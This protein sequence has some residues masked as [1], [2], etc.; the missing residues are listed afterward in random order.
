MKLGRG[1]QPS[2]L[3]PQKPFLQ[4]VKR[5]KHRS[6][7]YGGIMTASIPKIFARDVANQVSCSEV[8]KVLNDI[9][10]EN[11]HPDD[12]EYEIIVICHTLVCSK[13]KEYALNEGKH[14]KSSILQ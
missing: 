7:V 1:N 8:R 13:C 12:P 10:R 4:I 5:E 3:I 11:K 6:R 9:W 2:S 14:A